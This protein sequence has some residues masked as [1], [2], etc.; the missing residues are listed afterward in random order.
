MMEWLKWQSKILEQDD[1]DIFEVIATRG[2]GKTTF[3]LGWVTKDADISIFITKNASMIRK[4]L[5]ENI[6]T[7][8]FNLN[9]FHVISNLKQLRK[10]NTN[11]KKNIRIVVDEY[12]YQPE[13]TLDS[14][15]RI[16]GH[17]KYKALFIGTR[18]TKEDK[19]KIPFSKQYIVDIIQLISDQVISPAQ[20]IDILNKGMLDLEQ[21]YIEFG[22]P[23]EAN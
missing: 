19:F 8:D 15:D 10:L 12:F 6:K 11:P 5:K 22:A 13:I 7:L 9:E 14:L 4:K 20:L 1:L 17:K 3:S 18:R 16:L 2:A 21:F 23:F